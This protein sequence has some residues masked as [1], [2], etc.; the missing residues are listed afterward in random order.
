MKIFKKLKEHFDAK[1]KVRH[2]K[3]MA[4]IK[5]HH[6]IMEEKEI[7]HQRIKA[8][9]IREEEE[10]FNATLVS[11]TPEQKAEA[12]DFH[13]AKKNLSKAIENARLYES[14]KEERDKL[15]VVED[16]VRKHLA[17]DLHDGPTQFV[18]AMMMIL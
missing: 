16:E 4:S 7:Q 2:D 6:K 3:L 12:I 10:K 11:L 13:E 17:R 8:E 5:A 18:S 1:A 14:L 15:V 9:A